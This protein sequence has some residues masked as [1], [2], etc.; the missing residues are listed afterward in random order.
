MQIGDI[1]EVIRGVN[2]PS[3]RQI[4]NT[5][6]ELFPVIQIRDIENGE[7]R[8]E[9]IDEFPIQ[10]RDV[11]RV[12]AQPGDI[13]VSSRGTQQKIAVVPE[14]DGMILV[15]NMFIII[16][17]HS[18]KEVDPVYV[19]RF[20]ESPIGQYFFEAH[21]SGSIATVL[22]PNDIRSIE[23]PLLPIEQQQEMIRQLEEADELIRKA[24][25]ERK[26][27]TLMLIKN[28]ASELL[29]DQ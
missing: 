12:T 24:Y 4:E 3:R 25:E 5:D 11:Q 14:Y 16:R 2:L 20:L 18:T 22:T 7:I 26:K 6:G 27:N 17:L 9:T 28:L 13:L 19:K 15:S 10:T 29:S 21:Q 1:A 8:F 23:L